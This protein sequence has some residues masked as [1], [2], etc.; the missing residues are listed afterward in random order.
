MEKKSDTPC[1]YA[2][3]RKQ[4]EEGGVPKKEVEGQVFPHT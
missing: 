4:E 3:P 2:T 1:A